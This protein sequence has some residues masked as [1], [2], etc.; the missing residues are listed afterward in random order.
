MNDSNVYVTSIVAVLCWGFLAEE[1]W[2]HLWQLDIK[3]PV[4]TLVFLLFSLWHGTAVSPFM[5][6]CHFHPWWWNCLDRATWAWKKSQ[7][8][9]YWACYSLSASQAQKTWYWKVEE[10][11]SVSHSGLVLYHDHWESSMLTILNNHWNHSSKFLIISLD[12]FLIKNDL[13]SILCYSVS[14]MLRKKM[15]ASAY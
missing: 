14:H 7:G 8:Q 12:V 2:E 6:G 1:A 10:P 3:A 4:G 11:M 13:F 15:L 9:G 5:C